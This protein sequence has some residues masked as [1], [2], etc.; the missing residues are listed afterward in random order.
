MEL[1]INCEDNCLIRNESEIK[2][3]AKTALF[4]TQGTTSSIIIFVEGGTMASCDSISAGISKQITLLNNKVCPSQ[5]DESFGSCK[6]R[7]AK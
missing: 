1:M 4:N 6:P 3:L 2:H 5:Y 7:E